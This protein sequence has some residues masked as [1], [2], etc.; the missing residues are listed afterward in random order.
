VLNESRDAWRQ[1]MAVE[2]KA[3]KDATRRAASVGHE[4]LATPL[5]PGGIQDFLSHLTSRVDAINELKR[6]GIAA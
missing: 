6:R 5:P 2:R 1:R 4:Q 3:A